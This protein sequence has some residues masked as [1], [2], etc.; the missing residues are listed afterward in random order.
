MSDT[1]ADARLLSIV[2]PVRNEEA[3]VGP[4]C[5]EIRAALCGHPHEVILVDD[6][7]DD[8]TLDAA[9][10]ARE[11]DPTLR[12][13]SLP[14]HAGKSAAYEAGFRA[15]RGE[16]VA[17]LD[18]DLQDDPRDLLHLIERLP[19]A[20]LVVGWKQTGKSGPATFVFSRLAN[21]LL[22]R[23]TRLRLHDMNCP[24]RV[25]RRSVARNLSLRADFHRFIPL[26]AASRGARVVEVPVTNRPR[27]A[28][29]SKYTGRKYYASAIAFLGMALYLRFGDRPMSL[30][31][32]L[33]L[34]SLLAGVAI[35]LF[36]VFNWLLFSGNIDDDMPTLVLGVLLILIGTQFLSMGLL[37]E[38]VT[39]RLRASGDAPEE[40]VEL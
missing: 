38:I 28:G 24:V 27:G 39:R 10:Q 18:G 20:D 25:M 9:R 40:A 11:Q 19:E 5:R 17:T 7:S 30:F 16:L 36:V 31:G 23:T 22:R 15:A 1:A 32:P 3:N 21:M 14:R 33:G 4:L 6:G 29:T 8:G 37:A 2:V 12:I 26:L 34:I 35:D 13:L